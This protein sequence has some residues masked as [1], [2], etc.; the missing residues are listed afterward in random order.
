MYLN[1]FDFLY[2]AVGI[3]SACWVYFGKLPKDISVEEA[4]TLIGMCKNP[5]Y[6]N[7]LRQVDRTRGRRNVVLDLMQ[8]NG[9][10]TQAA[11]DTL[12][13][14]PLT[15]HFHK[16][17][18]TE[19]I[20]PYF[21]EYL[22]LTMTA[23][24]PER[25]N[26]P[27]YYRYVEDS[28]AWENNPLFGWCN[29]NR[30]PDGSYYNI[31]T[32]GLQ[33]YTTID[34]RMQAYAEQ[35]VTEHIGD[36]LQPVF[37]R[38]KSKSPT[39]PYSR[40][41]SKKEVEKIMDRAVKQTPRYHALRR[42]DKSEQEIR[43]IFDTPVEMQVFSWQGL[44]DTI[45]S[46][47]DSI[48]YMKMFLRAGFMAMDTHSGAVKAYVGGINYKHFQYD[49]VSMGRRQIGSTIKP[50]LYAMAME[51]GFTPCDEV[52]HVSQTLTDE[53]GRTWTPK[54]T[55][56]THIGEMVSIRWGLQHS[57]NWVTAHLIGQLSPYAFKKKLI[58][59]FGFSEPIDPVV[60]I[61]LG[62]CEVSVKE[63]VSGY[64]TFANG[65]IRIEPLFVSRIEDKNG[66]ILAALSTQIHDAIT[67]DANYKMLSMLR[68]VVDS[69]TGVG[70]RFR[71]GISAPMGGKT[72]TTNNNSDCWFMGFT[73]SLVGG[74]WVGGDDR[75]IHF[76]SMNEGQGARA[77]LP[78]MGIFLKKVFADTEL[79]YSPT[80]SFFV[81]ER[82]A[83]PCRT[84]DNLNDDS[85]YSPGVMDDIFN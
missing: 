14:L 6:Y 48:R 77:A 19:G 32:D 7:P 27:A 65:G 60:A 18:H 31:Y 57:D 75:D 41:L 29:K 56:K 35:A 82:Y 9:Y 54:N 50:F 49:M 63:M 78:I 24:K 45:L 53:L 66:N 71:Q 46:P 33:I 3:Q 39:A 22:R 76:A 23:Q 25:K 30:K 80:E 11:C 47:M 34:S 16:I 4:A 26:Y 10:I 37:F 59:S 52:L 13:A 68:S 73:P 85:N 5:S 40:M 21:R 84:I 70:M 12:K 79:G 2:N 58:E 55:V 61:C 69:G 42:E 43:K 36:Y 64:S 44:R 67:E 51:S 15:I 83:D 72:G 38:E 1:K 81:P 17:D 28:L 74:C 20:A 8:R 62:P